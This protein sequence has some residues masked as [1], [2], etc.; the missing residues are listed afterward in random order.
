MHPT[1]KLIKRLKENFKDPKFVISI[2]QHITILG[3]VV[4]IL[5][6]AAFAE[7]FYIE[8]MN[9]VFAQAAEQDGCFNH[10]MNNYL[11]DNEDLGNIEDLSSIGVYNVTDIATKPD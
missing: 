5:V 4:G 3:F 9:S 6:G 1:N 2:W 7:N 11:I 8:Q 10:F